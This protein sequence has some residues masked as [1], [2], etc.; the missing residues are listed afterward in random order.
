M[1]CAGR[2]GWDLDR[3]VHRVCMGVH[4]VDGEG[5]GVKGGVKGV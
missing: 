5:C 1:G 3:V 2:C 4:R